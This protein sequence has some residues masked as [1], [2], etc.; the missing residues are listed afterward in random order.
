MLSSTYWGKSRVSHIPLT[1]MNILSPLVA[2]C[3]FSWKEA[4]IILIKKIA[5]KSCL[6]VD[7]LHVC[8]LASGLSWTFFQ[9]LLSKD[10]MRKLT[11][12]KAGELPFCPT[13]A[14]IE[15]FMK[16]SIA[17]AMLLYF[18]SQTIENQ[19]HWHPEAVWTL[20]TDRVHVPW[21]PISE[22]WHF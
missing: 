3:L 5:S 18:Y 2:F 14:R 11:F 1:Q 21:K 10:I 7:N 6:K 22:A 12:Q 4:D 13:H 19:L 9:A 20:P 8:I 15:K 16:N 17:T